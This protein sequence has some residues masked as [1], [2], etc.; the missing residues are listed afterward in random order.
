L[1]LRYPRVSSERVISGP[2]LAQL[3]EALALLE[4]CAVVPSADEKA[5]W[6]AAI[7]G[8][9]DLAAAALE[10][11]CLSLGA[12]AGDIA[13]RRGRPQSSSPAVSV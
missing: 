13:P 12:F 7:E 5:L 9:E 1:R 2:G 11:F 10:R 3:Y 4:Q 6:R 8:R